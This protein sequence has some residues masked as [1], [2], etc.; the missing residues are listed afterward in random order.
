MPDAVNN[1]A[2]REQPVDVQL[3]LVELSPHIGTEV[4]GLDLNKPLD[5]FTIAALRSVWLERAVLVFRG[6]ELTQDA[7]VRFTRYFGKAGERVAST[8]TAYARA[9]VLPQIMLISNVRENGETIGALPDGELHFHHDMIQTEVPHMASMLYSIEVPTYGGETCFAAGYAAYETLDPQMK[10]RLEGKRV[11]NT[12]RYGTQKRGDMTGATGF[13]DRSLHPAFR[14]HDETGRKAIY[15]N[16]LMSTHVEGMS[17][18]EGEALLEAVFDHAE[19]PEFIYCHQW[20]VGDLLFWDNRNSM[21]ARK[22]FPADQR[23]MM[24]RTQILGMQKPH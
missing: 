21:H 22:D 9:N 15:V 10:G 17:L 13:E 4:R 14:I 20:Q 18:Q 3:D 1:S 19:K 23:R 5:D 8:N 2:R 11:Y 16:R 6:Q 24:W 7:L 12:Y